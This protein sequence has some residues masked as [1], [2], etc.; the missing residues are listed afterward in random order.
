ME[1]SPEV[2]LPIL[3]RHHDR[4]QRRHAGGFDEYAGTFNILQPTGDPRHVIPTADGPG[5]INYTVN[6]DGTVSRIR[7]QAS[8]AAH[9]TWRDPNLRNPYVMNWSAGFQYQPAGTWVVNLMYQGRRAW[10]WQR[11]WNINGIP[12]S[13]ALGGDRACRTR[14]SRRSRII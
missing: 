4:R 9:A 10:A 11:S 8:A 5:P 1:L 13:I 6:P 14:S 2:G 3:V 7:A 12:F